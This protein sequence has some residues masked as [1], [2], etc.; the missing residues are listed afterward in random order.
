MNAWRDTIAR[1]RLRIHSR[2]SW[3]DCWFDLFIGLVCLLSLMGAAY[4]A[5]RGFSS[6]TF[7]MFASFALGVMLTRAC[8]NNG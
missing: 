7:T 4:T 8:S 2:E 6:E 1:M 5:S 3:Q